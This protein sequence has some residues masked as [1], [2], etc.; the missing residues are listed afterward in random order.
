MP[1]KVW[2][3][4]PKHRKHQASDQAV[5]TMAGRDH[6][7]GPCAAR[8]VGFES[9]GFIGEWRAAGRRLEGDAGL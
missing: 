8:P 2:R 9:T 4:T 5:L 7:L 3:I 1:P 6:Y